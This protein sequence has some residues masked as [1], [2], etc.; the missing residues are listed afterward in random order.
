MKN[1]LIGL[2]LA[3]FMTSCATVHN[4]SS[5]LYQEFSQYENVANKN[6]IIEVASNFFSHSL[7]GRDYQS[8]PD[9]ASQLLFKSYMVN[10]DSHYE[11]MNEQEG[12]L[13]VNGYDE[14]NSPL[15]FSLKYISSNGRWLIDK[16]H[17][18]FVDNKKDFANSA[19]CPSEYPN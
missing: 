14:E 16:I 9:A 10:I 8:N 19:K 15:I 12:C 4:S 18:L 1:V 6:N 5:V 11:K 7:L 3:L 17:V 13:T 2:V